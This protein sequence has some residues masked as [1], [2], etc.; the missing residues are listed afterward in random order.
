M[1]F[2]GI[3]LDSHAFTQTIPHD[4]LH[5][6]RRILAEY[7]EMQTCT[8]R[9]LQSLI[10]KLMHVSGCVRG[11]RTFLNSILNVLRDAKSLS[12]WWI[13]MVFL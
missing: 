9:Q 8:K 10:G 12:Q 2:L 11:G 1:V 3:Q 5:G 13:L 6:C 7:L 4:K